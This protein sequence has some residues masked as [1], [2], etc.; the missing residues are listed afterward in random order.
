MSPDV[1]KVLVR[2]PPT[3]PLGPEPTTELSR[4]RGLRWQPGEVKSLAAEDAERLLRRPTYFERV[5]VESAVAA[6]PEKS[7][8]K[9]EEDPK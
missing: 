4:G 6:S 8:K 5:E 2:Y 1:T 9:K 3:A 7:K